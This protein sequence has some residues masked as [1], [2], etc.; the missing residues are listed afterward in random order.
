[1]ADT[2]GTNDSKL[3]PQTVQYKLPNLTLHGQSLQ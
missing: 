1:M 3:V 2:N